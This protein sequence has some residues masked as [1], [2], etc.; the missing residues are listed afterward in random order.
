MK[1]STVFRNSTKHTKS[2]RKKGTKCRFNFPRPPSKRTFISRPAKKV[3]K[4]SNNTTEQS[5]SVTEVQKQAMQKNDAK[6]VLE[7]IWNAFGDG[8]QN[9]ETVDELFTKIDKTQV[10]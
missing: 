3:T 4:V 10:I 5:Q 8:E 9:F 1:L 2:C 7:K 6:D